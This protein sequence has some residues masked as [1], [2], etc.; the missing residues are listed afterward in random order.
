M[1][2]MSKIIS[3]T[4]TLTL[5][6]A[7]T[8]A[9]AKE[10]KLAHFQSADLSSPVHAAAVA[11]ESCVEGKTS[12]SIDVQV[13]AAGQLG[14]GTATMEG[15]E[16]GVIQMAIVHDGPISATFKPFSVL[17]MPYLFD[18]QAM[19]WSVMD[20]PFGDDLAESMR[21]ETGIKM[22]GVADNGVRN[23]TNNVRPV[24]SPDD[25]KDLKMRVMTAPVWVK[26]VESLGA[27]ATPVPWPELPGALQQGVVD[28]QENGVT[29][30]VNAS[31]YQHQKYVS[32]DGHVFSW[33]AYL[34]SDQFYQG[35]DKNEQ[36]AI[37]QC[38]NI[39]KVIHRGMTAA[40]DANASAILEAKG[41]EVTPVSPEQKNQFREATQ[42]AVRDF[43]VSEIGNDWPNKLDD[44]I[45]QYRA[46]Y[47]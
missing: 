16:F 26:L 20:G 45:Q 4:A 30:I 21:K 25:M 34:M 41:M 43:I 1:N 33:H 8:A 35:L 17:A 3:T 27:S 5:L 36:V 32:L 31:L 15:L 23:F 7:S 38:V 42:P 12:N 11:F 13:Y 6:A 28:G 14:D 19:A 40:Q 39:A 29:N 22:F 37:D 2:T 18:D 46:S 9:S 44:A 47:N 10:L 24:S